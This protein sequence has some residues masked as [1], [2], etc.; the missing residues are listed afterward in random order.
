MTQ[1]VGPA[2]TFAIAGDNLASYDVNV[3]VAGTQNIIS[4]VAPTGG[5]AP[6]V[7]VQDHLRVA[8]GVEVLVP[9]IVLQTPLPTGRSPPPN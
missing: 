4:F 2:L 5:M 3:S 8:T 9:D 6:S 7:V 1:A